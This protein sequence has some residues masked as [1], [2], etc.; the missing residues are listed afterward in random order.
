MNLLGRLCE[1][2]LGLVYHVFTPHIMLASAGL[3]I[4]L[5]AA[6]WR[7][8]IVVAML[9][10]AAWSWFVFKMLTDELTSSD[11]YDGYN[12]NFDNHRHK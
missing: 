9:V 10:I 8:L 12:P 6:W 3:I 5:G 7:W 4:W 2:C 1:F 11:P